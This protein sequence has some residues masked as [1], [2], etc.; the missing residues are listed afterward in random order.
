MLHG[1]STR[2]SGAG[3][4]IVLD[5]GKEVGGLVTVTFAGA[6]DVN[7]S[8]GIAFTESSLY[9][10]PNSDASNGGRGPDGAIFAGVNGKGSFS[11]P[12]DKLR[13]GFRYLTIFLN[14]NGWV[15]LSGAS[16]YFTAAPAMANLRAY[17][18]YFR[19]DD[20]LLNRIWYAGAYTVQLDTIDPQQGRASPPP[21]SGWENNATIAGGTSALTDGAKR[22]RKVWPGDLGISQPTAF[23]ST[24]DTE[25]ERNALNALYAYQAADGGF[26]YC[27]PP[28]YRGTISDTYHL[29]TLI[30]SY[31]YYLE[32]KDGA[33]LD[34][35][36]EQYKNGVSY[37]MN[38][39]DANGVLSIDQTADW[40]R[41]PQAGETLSGN[42]LLYRVL[43]TG[44][45][46][47]ESEGDAS[48]AQD[49][50]SAAASLKQ[51]ANSIFWDQSSGDFREAPGV[52]QHPQDGNSL[53][54]W[55][56]LADSPAKAWSVSR[57]LRANWNSFG[58]LTP[59]R[60]N[61]IATFPG[62]LEV[63]GHFAANDDQAGLDLIRLEW[64]YM[65]LSPIGTRSTFWEGYLSDGSFDYNGSYMSHAHGWATGPTSAL[66]YYVLGIMPSS[67]P[68]S[69]YQF[70]PHPGYLKH[71]AGRLTLPDGPIE[72]SWERDGSSETFTETIDAPEALSGR[73]GIPAFSKDVK[74]FVDGKLAWGKC[75]TANPIT[76][77]GEFGRVSSDS[78]Y[79]YFDGVKGS[80]QFTATANCDR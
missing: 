16:L 11:S 58:A 25:S 32:T 51:A 20:D 15:E 10:G 67:S 77:Q 31:D 13:G 52:N 27:G 49:F 19:S 26:A 3:S 57:A 70:V 2:L 29:W 28:V 48:A 80:H 61:A 74:V 17:P 76:P 63:L 68:G 39:V 54:L 59:E 75:V 78:N 5:F 64:G 65:L 66:T 60:P 38:K 36:W 62:S 18:N 6:S 37:S 45:Y 50:T 73:I 69:S 30:A 21:V 71:V 35:H 22:D 79:I 72:V 44:S 4:E 41:T 12:P 56:G 23:V 9:I 33:W 46:L 8:I 7:Q 1:G 53:A 43:V 55:F 34:S 40:G 47:A 14:S 42:A 24:N